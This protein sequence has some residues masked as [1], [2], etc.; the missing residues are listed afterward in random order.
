SPFF[1]A[2][3]RPRPTLFPYTTLFR[4]PL[5]SDPGARLVRSAIEAG[6][7]VV[8]VPGASALLTALVASGIS[9][10]RF[11]FYGFL[12]RRGGARDALLRE[13][14]R[15]RY[16]SV[17][18][19]APQR[20]AQLLED[21]RVHAGEQRQVVLARELTKLHE[22]FLRAPLGEALWRVREIEPRGEYV[23]IVEGAAED[24]EAAAGEAEAARTLARALLSAGVS[25]S[26]AA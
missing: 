24:P 9:A 3:R 13:I 20:V 19:E 17:L 2:P 21:L 1:T 6:F 22:E 11:T 16:T 4:S 15:S 10:D 18:Y 14:A 7:D 12:P 26:T 5:L 23:V 25:P 8:P